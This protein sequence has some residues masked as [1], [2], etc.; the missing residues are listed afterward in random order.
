MNHKD[1]L[2]IADIISGFRAEYGNDNKIL[3]ELVDVLIDTFKHNYSSFDYVQFFND[4][5]YATA[6]E[7]N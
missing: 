1:F 5:E 2:R 7:A 3:E 4:C 6:K